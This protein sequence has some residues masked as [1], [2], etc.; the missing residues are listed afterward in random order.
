[1]IAAPPPAPPAA[2]GGSSGSTFR[3]SEAAQVRPSE[4]GDMPTGDFWAA[5]RFFVEKSSLPPKEAE[6]VVAQFQ[7]VRP[8]LRRG[9]HPFHS[10]FISR[11][12]RAHP[13]R[14]TLLSAHARLPPAAARFLALRNLALAFLSWSRPIPGPRP[15]ARHPL[16]RRHRRPPRRQDRG[17]GGGRWGSPLRAF[18]LRCLIRHVTKIH[19]SC[20]CVFVQLCTSINKGPACGR[21]PSW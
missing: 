13:L 21:R 15:A 5:L 9:G 6:R 10:A 8:H 11:A 14:F 4:V 1:M 16:P 17:H 18:L 2:E 12:T 20:S 19:P 3:S 7:Q